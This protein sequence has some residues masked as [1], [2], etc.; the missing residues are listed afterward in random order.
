MKH[1]IERREYNDDANR[2]IDFMIDGRPRVTI[3]QILRS[4]VD[5]KPRAPEISWSAPH[6]PD[7][8]FTEAAGRALIEAAN[9]CREWEAEM[10]QAAA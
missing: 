10:M 4:P 9:V 7:A 6:Q 3:S 1:E 8:D 5:F 2:G